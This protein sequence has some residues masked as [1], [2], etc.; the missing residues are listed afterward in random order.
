MGDRGFSLMELMVVLVI[1]A[2]LMIIA[3]PMF[4]NAFNQGRTRSDDTTRRMI[5][6]AALDFAN[7]ES[8]N[9]N[10]AMPLCELYETGYLASILSDA[11]GEVIDYSRTRF[12]I[13]IEGRRRVANITSWS[14][15]PEGSSNGC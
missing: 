7:N 8:F 10:R 4:I 15:L 12:E 13:S 3:V 5:E 11:N 6:A 14:T 1:L 2:L 9:M